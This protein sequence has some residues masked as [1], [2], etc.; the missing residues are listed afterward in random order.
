MNMVWISVDSDVNFFSN[1]CRFLDMMIVIFVCFTLEQFMTLNCVD[2]IVTLLIFSD[3]SFLISK[4]T[5]DFKIL[6]LLFVCVCVCDYNN[7]LAICLF[8]CI[9]HLPFAD[10]NLYAQISIIVTSYLIFLLHQHISFLYCGSCHT[11]LCSF[12]LISSCHIICS[13][14]HFGLIQSYLMVPGPHKPSL[15][16][17]F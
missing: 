2:L 10:A 7:S 15:G 3:C 9:F 1:V 16:I 5:A 17:I 8:L 14:A 12:I 4:N 6:F 11:H 13:Y